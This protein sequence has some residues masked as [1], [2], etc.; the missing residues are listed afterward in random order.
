MKE[1]VEQAGFKAVAAI[2]F[3]QSDGSDSEYLILILQLLILICLKLSGV[4][5]I[6][7]IKSNKQFTKPAHYYLHRQRRFQMKILKRI[8]GLFENLLHK[9]STNIEDL[10]GHN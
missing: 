10:A 5:L 3:Y 1:A 9:S 2:R 7:M 8:D 4:E 6:E